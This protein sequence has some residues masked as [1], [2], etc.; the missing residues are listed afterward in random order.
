M[1]RVKKEVEAGFGATIANR[2]AD[3]LRDDIV[4][5]RI[6][7]GS[8]ITAK[9]IADKYGVSS[10]PVREAFSMLCGENLL[11]MNPY[12][13]ATVIAVTPE[14]VAQLNDLQYALESLLIELSMKKGYS[15]E[16]L[17]QLEDVNAQMA[18]LTE[19]DWR[20]K[21]TPLNMKFHMLAYS[22]CADHMAYQ[23]FA[24]NI[25]QLAFIRK[26]HEVD[27]QRMSQS[28]W[29]HSQLIHAI[30]NNDVISAVTIVKLHTL[31]SKQYAL[32]ENFEEDQKE[33]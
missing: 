13:G 12:R 29:E 33:N 18:A 5:N 17:H 7:P 24:R 20:E 6:K 11:E 23:L 25:K 32:T 1:I 22:P 19:K 3:Q 27:Y 4:S 16:L 30:R 9:E 21:R 10:M 2:V 31:N 26:Y 8:R 28:V 14:L 15:E